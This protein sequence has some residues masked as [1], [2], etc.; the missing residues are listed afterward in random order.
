M[1]R[2][3]YAAIALVM[4]FVPNAH[5]DGQMPWLP[6]ILS[7]H[8]VVQQ[9]QPVPVWGRDLAGSKVSVSM[10]GRSAE[11]TADA[12]G[13]WKAFL[14]KL[15]AGGPYSLT[16]TGSATRVVNDVLV[17]ELWLGAGQSNMEL[18]MRVTKDSA[19]ELPKASDEQL[20][21][22]TA[23]RVASFTPEDDVRGA[24]QVCS[25]QTA[26]DFSSVAYHFGRSL[27]ADLKRPVGMI[28][29]SWGGTPAED[30]TPRAALEQEPAVKDLLAKWDSET[31]RQ[32]LWK[33]GQPFE[34]ELSEIR[35]IPKDPK[36]KAVNIAIEAPRAG[37]LGGRW[38]HSEKF[39]SKGA[40]EVLTGKAGA[41]G[42]FAGL[43]HGGAWGSAQC[44]LGSGPVDLSA[45]EAVEF[46]AKG[47]GHFLPTLGQ[48]SITDYDYYAGDGFELGADWQTL[49][50]PLDKLKQGGWGEGKAFT[51]GAISS[52]NFGIQVTYW[53]DL[54]ALAYNGMVHPL[55]NL[56]IQGVLWYQ[57]ESNAGRANAY[58]AL[59]SAMIKSWRAAFQAPALPFYLVQLPGWSGGGNSWGALREAQREVSLDR[60]LGHVSLISTLDL[61]ESHDIHPKDKRPV[62]ERLASLVLEG[63]YGHGGAGALIGAQV[64]RAMAKGPE[65]QVFISPLHGSLALKGDGG[66]EVAG[67]DG[68]FHSASAR[69]NKNSIILSSPEVPAPLQVRHAWAD[70]PQGYAFDA[71]TPLPCFLLK[72]PYTYEVSKP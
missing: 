24:W 43:V 50:M 45:Y 48:P 35:L 68:I 21:L 9:G 11:A 18:A 33:D 38:S 54:G 2:L 61:G 7:D 60:S 57:G 66:F 8:M 26:K 1:S 36:A 58:A 13:H 59:L 49:R 39:D 56:P 55:L 63:R 40:F 72:L 52:L 53:P 44:S 19:T 15:A 64:T 17:G 32:A 4:L 16:V 71:A 14:P 27:R 28:V 65:V 51:P 41:I 12:Q 69:T 6:N 5:A 25:P 46:K 10:G 23:D 20:R 22:F 70:D 29:T 42:R 67:A 37:E 3:Y 30:W 31:E 47:K 62:G 34:L